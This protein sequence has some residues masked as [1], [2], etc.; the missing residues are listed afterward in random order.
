MR[1]QERVGRKANGWYIINDKG[2]E[3]EGPFWTMAA[4]DKALAERQKES[5]K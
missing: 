1:T 5:S 2:W 3:V 4:A